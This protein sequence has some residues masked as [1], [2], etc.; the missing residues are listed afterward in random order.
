METG[1]VPGVILWVGL[2]SEPCDGRCDDG[3]GNV[4]TAVVAVAVAV[5]VAVGADVDLG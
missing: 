2:E 5:S 1:V 4:A 3:G